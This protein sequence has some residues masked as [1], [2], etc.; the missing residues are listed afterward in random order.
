M[1]QTGWTYVV[2]PLLYENATT[3]LTNVTGFVTALL[4][5]DEARKGK[6]LLLSP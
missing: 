5:L 6:G 2:V 1:V 4:S 3:G